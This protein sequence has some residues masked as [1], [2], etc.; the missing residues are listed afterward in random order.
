MEKYLTIV[1]LSGF[2]SF[3]G[4]GFLPSD[5]EKNAADNNQIASGETTPESSAT[6]P[7]DE[8]EPASAV[9]KIENDLI[10]FAGGTLVVRKTSQMYGEKED[11]NWGIIALIDG[12]PQS[13]W[14]SGSNAPENQSVVLEL[15]ARTTFESFGFDTANTQETNSSA[16]DVTVEVSDTNADSGFQKVLEATLEK[17]KDNQ[18]FAAA[19]RTPA[20]WIRLTI[21]NNYGSPRY[22]QLMEFSGFGM[23]EDVPIPENV[24]GTYETNGGELHIKQQGAS[25]VGCYNYAYP[26]LIEGGIEGR[27]LKLITTRLEKDGSGKRDSKIIMIISGEGKK[28]TGVWSGAQ[29]DAP[30]VGRWDGVK[31]S[32]EVGNCPHLPDLDKSDSVE[33]N[34]EKTLDSAGRAV[35]YGINFDFNSDKIKDESKP[36]LDNI[37]AVL[38]KNPDWKM[39]VEGHTDNVGG[40]EFNQTLSEK[41][42][43]SVKKYLTENGI[44]EARLTAVG[45]GMTKPIAEN[46]SDA[47]R[48]QNRRVELVKL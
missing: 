15:P 30:Y 14:S 34:L 8:N 10:T 42:A 35:I 1:V 18:R 38:K 26:Y 41:R 21:K 45:F 9:G 19:S 44:G 48:A 47:G 16:K 11:V 31:T 39:N 6:P 3:F 29:P 20:R 33:N 23:R 22:T 37:V 27:T 17:E 24:G 28:L 2:I 32:S 36:T 12:S 25:I 43:A 4:C 13:G 5:S 46:D 7:N 40:S